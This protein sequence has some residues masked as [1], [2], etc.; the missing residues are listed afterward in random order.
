MH[1]ESLFHDQGI[2]LALMGMFVVF[3]ALALVVLAI[4]YLPKLVDLLAKWIPDEKAA[5]VSKEQAAKKGDITDEVLAVLAAAVTEAVGPSHRIV[6]I[7]RGIP[8]NV[9]WAAEGRRQHHSS[10]RPR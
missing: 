3:V 10:H 4:S 7:G 8:A 9:G 1:F 6:H 2:P 5:A